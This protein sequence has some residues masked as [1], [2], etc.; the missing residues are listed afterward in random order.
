MTLV[1]NLV[2]LRCDDRAKRIILSRDGMW[3]GDVRFEQLVTT[4]HLSGNDRDT[5]EVPHPE[6]CV[7]NR[8]GGIESEAP[9]QARNKISPGPTLTV[10]VCIP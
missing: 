5:M 7:S 2:M 8:A 6:R 10:S 9:C 1:M 4:R 3:V